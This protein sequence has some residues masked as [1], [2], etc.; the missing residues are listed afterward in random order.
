MS[1]GAFDTKSEALAAEKY[2]KTK[3]VRVLLGILKITQ[4]NSVMTWKLIPMQAFTSDSDIDWSKSISDIDQQLYKKYNLSAD[5]INF[6]ESKVQ[7][8]Q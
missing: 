7:T 4:H 8:M 2:I 5:E 6:I 1:I 3:F